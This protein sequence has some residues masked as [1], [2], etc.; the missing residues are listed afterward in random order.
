MHNETGDNIELHTFRGRSMQEAVAVLKDQLGPDAVIVKTRRARNK[1]GRFVEISARRGAS[2]SVTNAVMGRLGAAAGARGASAAYAQTAASTTPGTPAGFAG[3]TVGGS[4]KPFAE[5]A[6]WLASQIQQRQSGAPQGTPA[7][8]SLPAELLALT[9]GALPPGGGDLPTPSYDTPIP[10][11]AS[12]NQYATM[13]PPEGQAAATTSPIEPPPPGDPQPGQVPAASDDEIKRLRDELRDLKQAVAGLTG[14]ELERTDTVDSQPKTLSGEQFSAAIESLDARVDEIRGLLKG[15][16][17]VRRTGSVEKVIDTLRDL[18]VAESHSRELAERVIRAVPEGTIDDGDVLSIL[19]RLMADDMMCGGAIETSGHRRRVLAFVGPTGVGKT[20]TIAKV[21]SRSRLA[22]LSVAL[23]NLDTLHL[24]AVEKLARYAEIL[25][26]PLRNVK[27]PS[28][29]R[30][31]LDEFSEYDVVLIDTNGRNP[32]ASD[33]VDTLSEFFPS[34]WGGELVLTLSCSTRER[35][36]F[37]SIDSFGRLGLER[38]CMTKMD[39]TD[40]FGGIYSVIR[41]ACRPLI[42]V[43]NGQRVPDDIEVAKNT[44]LAQMILS[45]DLN[46]TVAMAG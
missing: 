30:D 25:D 35:D 22:G 36:L 39:E 11:S 46:S 17:P 16:E 1:D 24:V 10:P 20:T 21:A 45:T 27:D 37:A 44:T 43:T 2:S 40:A 3:A 15:E 5:R 13:G 31:A 33:Q 9:Q 14:G 29:L 7:L 4:A 12:T 34:G 19:E 28:E 32:R 6:A 41:R 42:W 23:I 26:A 38:L 18:G 8:N